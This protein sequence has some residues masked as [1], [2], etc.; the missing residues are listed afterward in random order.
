M[1]KGILYWLVTVC[2]CWGC[3]GCASEAQIPP[4]ESG[5]L[6]KIKFAFDAIHPDGLRGPPNGLVS[7]S[8]EFCI[9]KGEAFREE[10]RR[11]DPSVQ[12]HEGSRGRTGFS[13]DQALCIG[14]TH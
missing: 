6:D 9:P 14:S 2:L 7:V 8:Y 4:P 12:I 1:S 13:E 10:V 5:F 11:I 3:I